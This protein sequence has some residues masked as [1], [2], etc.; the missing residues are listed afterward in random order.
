MLL[1]SGLQ[2][3]LPQRELQKNEN[4]FHIIIGDRLIHKETTTAK[5]KQIEI[6]RRSLYSIKVRTE[7]VNRESNHHEGKSF[8]R[9]LLELL[10]MT[11]TGAARPFIESRLGVGLPS[12]DRRRTISKR[13]TEAQT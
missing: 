5:R 1:S 13:G 4:I 2:N 7:L 9:R 10:G 8:R 3:V 11:R 12:R 6:T